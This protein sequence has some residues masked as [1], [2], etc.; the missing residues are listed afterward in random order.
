M[1][2]AW[3]PVSSWRRK[4]W[5]RHLVRWPLRQTAPAREGSLQGQEKCQDRVGPGQR[6][7][8]QASGWAKGKRMLPDRRPLPPRQVERV[9]RWQLSES[10]GGNQK[11]STMA[12]SSTPSTHA[13]S[14]GAGWVEQGSFRKAADKRG[15][16][17]KG[18]GAYFRLSEF[19]NTQEKA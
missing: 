4:A 6:R 12:H 18:T 13:G 7:P 19:P 2:R 1:P 9:R 3:G 16:D 10:Q 5:V 17:R 11:F 15:P 8:E 14:P